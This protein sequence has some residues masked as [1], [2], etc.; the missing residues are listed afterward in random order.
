MPA[1]NTE[2]KSLRCKI[3]W[4]KI[5]ASVRKT[6]LLV[7]N[8]RTPI[9]GIRAIRGYC[10]LAEPTRIGLILFKLRFAENIS[11][12]DLECRALLPASQRQARLSAQ[13]VERFG[14]APFIFRGDL[15]K[16]NGADAVL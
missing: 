12:K 2:N 9:R 16:K 1:E 13:V 14:F 5:I 7:R 8:V 11:L 6:G 3:P 15:W 4:Q 10:Y